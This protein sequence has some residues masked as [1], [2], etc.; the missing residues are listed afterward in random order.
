MT[1]HLTYLAQMRGVTSKPGESMDLPAGATMLD[2][3]ARLEAL[4][5][6]APPLLVFRGEE[7]AALSREVTLTDG[8]RITL[9]TPMAGGQA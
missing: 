6:P 2:L 1:I 8:D 7:Q 4:Y 9:L 5:G 3:M